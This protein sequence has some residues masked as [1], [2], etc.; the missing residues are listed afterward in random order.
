MFVNFV[1]ALELN[2]RTYA[3]HMYMYVMYTYIAH[4]GS[5]WGEESP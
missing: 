4:L 1:Y 5:K 3:I 2:T